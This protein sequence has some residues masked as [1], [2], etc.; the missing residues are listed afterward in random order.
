MTDYRKA[1]GLPERYFLS[2]G[3]MVEKKNLATLI[4]AY[5]RYCDEWR[6]TSDESARQ[7]PVSLVFVGSGELE[8]ALREKARL[9]GLRVVDCTAAGSQS[10]GV[11]RQEGSTANCKLQ[12]EHSVEK[13]GAAL[14]RGVVSIG[15][16]L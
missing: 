14:R 11:T 7:A 9:L 4:A 16:P 8:S 3:R 13:H 2:L 12:T 1:Y 15:W 10:S 6:V 5:G